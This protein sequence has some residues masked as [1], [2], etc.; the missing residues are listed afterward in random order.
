ML[1]DGLEDVVL[2]EP[3]TAQVL[4]HELA[5]V[6]EKRRAAFEG[7]LQEGDVLAGLDVVP[8]DEDSGRNEPARD[9]CVGR[10]IAAAR[11]LGQPSGWQS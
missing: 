3:F 1:V 5:V 6:D 4:R 10:T 8:G 7:S 2:V 9:G 11:A